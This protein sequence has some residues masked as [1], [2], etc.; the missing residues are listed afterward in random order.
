MR[1]IWET[2]RDELCE[3]LKVDLPG[4]LLLSF[5]MV[6]VFAAGIAVLIA[7]VIP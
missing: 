1:T 5:L 4:M 2:F 3:Y 6:L 7:L